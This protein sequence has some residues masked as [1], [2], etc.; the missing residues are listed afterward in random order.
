MTLG[1]LLIFRIKNEF[2]NA[3]PTIDGSL[4]NNENVKKVL[5]TWGTS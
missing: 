4:K 3:L 1:N 2:L 5:S